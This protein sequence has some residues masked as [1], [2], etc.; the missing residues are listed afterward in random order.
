MNDLSQIVPKIKAVVFDMDGVLRIGNYPIKGSEK[1]FGLLKEKNIETMILTNE[2][3]FSTNKIRNDL[4]NMGI[5]IYNTPIYT[6]GICVFN[7]LNNKFTKGTNNF[8]L[9][10]IGEEGLKNELQP[11]SNLDNVKICD[12]PPKYNTKLFLV[13]GTVNNI[14]M[15]VLE[16]AI[17]WVKA[18]AKIILTCKDMSDPSSKGDFSLGMPKHILHL[19]KYNLKAKSYALGKPSP[20]VS[21]YIFKSFPKLEPDEILFIGDTLSTDIRLAEESGMKSL[22]VLSGNTKKEALNVYVTEPDYV[23]DSINDFVTILSK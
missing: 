15:L 1:I 21:N 20:L 3:R 11:L 16:K 23:I 7:Y 17:K 2:C 13:I 18:G 9:G 6:A 19:I 12:V 22:L 14:N 10:I 4:E 5:N 8:T